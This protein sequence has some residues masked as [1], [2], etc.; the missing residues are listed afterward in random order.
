[1]TQ[2]TLARLKG[3]IS[4][5][6]YKE[7]LL[8][9]FIVMACV[10]ALT[11]SALDLRVKVWDE[12]LRQYSW[13][14]NMETKTDLPLA[15][16]ILDLYTSETYN[17]S[18]ENYK[19]R[20]QT[21]DLPESLDVYCKLGAT[22]LAIDFFLDDETW[23]GKHLSNDQEDL[24]RLRESLNCFE[25]IWLPLREQAGNW[26]FPINGLA[27]LKNVRFAH[28]NT[29][30]SVL[31]E[32]SL[33]H[34]SP[35]GELRV[36]YIAK[37]LA[38]KNDKEEQLTPLLMNYSLESFTRLRFEDLVIF[39]PL[40]QV[41]SADKFQAF[42]HSYFNN[43]QIKYPLPL[44]VI[45]AFTHDAQDQH[46]TAYNL[47][48]PLDLPKVSALPRK[49]NNGSTIGGRVITYGAETKVSFTPGA[50]LIASTSNAIASQKTFNSITFNN[51]GF[52]IVF[53]VFLCV[54]FYV[55]STF[56]NG[57][58]VAIL[59]IGSAMTYIF[60]SYILLAI[61]HLLVPLV[62][63]LVVF[64]ILWLI[65]DYQY[66]AGLL[67]QLI[68]L[69][70]TEINYQP[71]KE[72]DKLQPIVISMAQSHR[73]SQ[74]DQYKQLISSVDLLSFWLQY[75][76][77]LVMSENVKNDPSLNVT[78]HKKDWERWYKPTLGTYLYGLKKL[79]DKK[80]SQNS[81]FP[82]LIALM[83]KKPASQL[84]ETLQRSLNF[85]NEWKHFASSAYSEGHMDKVLDD[86]LM[87]EQELEQNISFLSKFILIKTKHLKL[88]ENET[89]YWDCL[90]Y[91]GSSTFIDEFATTD[92]LQPDTLYLFDTRKW[93][94]YANTL[95][96]EPWLFASEC[97]HHNR[98]E[99]F[100]YTGLIW[101]A[102]SRTAT[103]EI[104][105]SGLTESCCPLHNK[106][107]PDKLFERLIKS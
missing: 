39:K 80:G 8:A 13:F 97:T 68:N 60:V 5:A 70:S 22:T 83:N 32:P 73:D 91:S 74:T 38:K 51:T 106:E 57:Y 61:A 20:Y 77:L 76:A 1:M 21:Y 71:S 25:R 16:S 75:I 95:C 90:V 11:I 79:V 104:K 87:T 49:S 62:L 9:V 50:Y 84:E 14:F 107:I 36:P 59:F 63:P 29:I 78:L 19:A 24:S 34:D 98:E 15:T 82:E 30:E 58:R 26:I 105:Y 43:E 88:S 56:H 66:G 4:L 33:A 67:K 55:S 54:I 100:F 85:R 81:W 92:T 86:I 53:C 99:V 28:V 41:M 3:M 64:F 102:N 44:T 17:A 45:A 12:K 2:Y 52:I 31:Y 96:L 103:K 10:F 72:I 69:S 48:G 94:R 27:N 35:K 18:P 93:G 37:A 101:N 47:G 6:R 89:H 7:A 46:H 42:Y 23:M 40:K 65:A